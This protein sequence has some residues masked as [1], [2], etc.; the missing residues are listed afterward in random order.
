M[1][2]STCK[3]FYVKH[4]FYL[5]RYYE[6]DNFRC[7]AHVFENKGLKAVKYDINFA[8]SWNYSLQINATYVITT[9]SVSALF[10]LRPIKTWLSLGSLITLYAHLTLISLWFK[11]RFMLHF[12]Q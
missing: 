9:G 3:P 10:T 1:N 2:V 12:K 11:T 6:K 5:D 7:K 8:S 4:Y